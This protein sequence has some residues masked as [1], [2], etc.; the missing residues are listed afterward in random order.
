[1][2]TYHAVT[3]LDLP[4]ELLLDII[5]RLPQPSVLHFT[6]TC[7]TFYQLSLPVLYDAVRLADQGVS[8]FR[9]K[10]QRSDH[11]LSWVHEL[12]LLR[13]D[14]RRS[15]PYPG[16]RCV[17]QDDAFLSAF[18]NLRS[19]DTLDYA[20]M[21][22]W[23]ELLR[24]MEA[25]PSSV[26][27]FRGRVCTSDDNALESLGR[28][29]PSYQTLELILSPE[30]LAFDLIS[31]DHNINNVPPSLSHVFPNLAH[32]SLTLIFLSGCITSFL[33]ECHFPALETFQLVNRDAIMPDFMLDMAHADALLVF[34]ASHARTLR[35]LHLPAWAIEPEVGDRFAETPLTLRNMCSGLSL[36]HY[37]ARSDA[38]SSTLLTLS[39]SPSAEL[40]VFGV[41]SLPVAFVGFPLVHTLELAVNHDPTGLVLGLAFSFDIDAIPATFPLLEFLEIR[42]HETISVKTVI[43]YL[44]AY[45]PRAL[46]RCRKLTRLVFIYRGFRRETRDVFCVQ[47]REGENGA[48][49]IMLE[50]MQCP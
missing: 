29:Y 45:H 24:V 22:G 7:K 21:K 18:P 10:I 11:C 46:L 34:F 47:C 36:L 1:M 42:V 48:G 31:L 43:T 19:F 40:R 41:P 5:A 49:N 25:L 9:S 39:V 3:I 37:L 16:A 2:Y 28:V 4:A 44:L 12:K 8:E 23:S 30:G 27:H 32:L 17:F 26:R 38:F 14:V 50:R 15:G 35:D 20:R 33:R 13:S 6:I